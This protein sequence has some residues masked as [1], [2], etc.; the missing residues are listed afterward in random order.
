L[1]GVASPREEK[2]EKSGEC[3]SPSLLLSLSPY[4]ILSIPSLPYLRV[5]GDVS[6]H[7]VVHEVIPRTAE[8][9]PLGSCRERKERQ[10][11]MGSGKGRKSQRHRGFAPLSAREA[12]QR[13]E[14]LLQP[15]AKKDKVG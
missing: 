14:H 10:R 3:V 1:P 9:S 15:E 13:N 2:E 12:D 4:L 5:R 11:K 7:P 6:E 8:A